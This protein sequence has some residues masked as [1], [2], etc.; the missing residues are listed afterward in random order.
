MYDLVDD[1]VLRQRDGTGGLLEVSL[2]SAL[3]GVYLVHSEAPAA[4]TRLCT[5]HQLCL[6]YPYSALGID[7][8]DV[9]AASL[10]ERGYNG[11]T[12]VQLWPKQTRPLSLPSLLGT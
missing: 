3:Q 6:R 1:G 12:S 2:A 4:A 7:A 5:Y 9:V 10:V 8:E 11:A